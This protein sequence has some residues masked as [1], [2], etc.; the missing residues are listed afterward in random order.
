M[1]IWRS[2]KSLGAAAIRDGV[3]VLPEGEQAADGLERLARDCSGEGGNGWVIHVKA[4]NEPDEAGLIALFDR[5][6]EYTEMQARWKEVLRDGATYTEAELNRVHKKLQRDWEALQAI[7]FFPGS[8]A[9][10]A[11]SA[12]IELSKRFQLALSPDEPSGS[13]GGVP[14]LNLKDYQ[15]RTWATRKRLWIDRV[16]SAWLIRRFIDTRAKFS[17][18]DS[19][20][21]CPAGALGFDFDGAT[22]SHVGNLVTFETLMSSFGLT[23][24]PALIRLA[25][26]VHYLDIGGVAVPEAGGFEAIVSGARDHLGSD[27][28]LLAEI[29]KVLDSLYVHFSRDD[30]SA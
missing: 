23:K 29:A 19:P 4:R 1:R 9:V 14:R 8:A 22:F 27:D 10:D 13:T 24:D 11:E 18:L 2:L 17:W 25:A 15:G 6:A 7:D 12:W 5:T 20:A 30:K 16:S 26:M 21:S 3:Y 28:E